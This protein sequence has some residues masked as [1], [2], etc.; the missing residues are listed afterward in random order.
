MRLRTALG[1]ASFVGGLA[2]LNERL[3]E[4]DD[5]P[6]LGAEERRYQWRG[7][8]LAYQV[9][10]KPDAPPLLLVHGIYAG[11]SSYEFRKNFF[12]LAEDFRVYALDLLGCGSSDKPRWRYAPEDIGAQ[13]EDFLR[14]EISRPAHLVASSLSAA[15]VMPVAVRSPRLFKRLVF[16]CP[17]GLGG[18]LDRPSGRLGDLIYALLRLPILG[19]SLYH[20]IVSRRGIRY[21]LE[22]MAYHDPEFVTDTL[23]EDY[24]GA[25]HGP[26]AKY[27]PIAFI[28]GKLNLGVS[29][30]F[31]RIPHK[32]LVAWGQEAKATPVKEIKNFITKNPR[33]EPRIFRDAALLPHDERAATFNEEV[34]KFLFVGTRRKARPC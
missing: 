32:V 18:S 27:L 10:G 4:R 22:N 17:T 19:D 23:I 9:A 26:G 28:S 30:Y 1:I 31:P 2:V 16:I 7:G 15:L 21:Y 12:E 29:G 20:A 34:K 13:V 25:T 14:E 5:S 8:N 24:Y 33:S 6:R 3:K 11:A